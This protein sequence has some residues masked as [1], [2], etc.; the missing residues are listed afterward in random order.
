MTRL[1]RAGMIAAGVITAAIGLSLAGQ[2]VALAGAF[3]VTD[4]SSSISD[5]GSL[6]YAVANAAA[7]DTITIAPSPS[8]DLIT[9]TGTLDIAENLTITGPGA[10]AMAV[11]GGGTVGVF[12]ITSPGA[13]VGISGLTIENGGATSLGGDGIGIANDGGTVTITGSTVSGNGISAGGLSEGGGINNSGG[14]SVTI[15][16]ST[17]SGNTAPNGGGINNSGGGSVTITGSTVSG[18]SVGENGYGAG[19]ANNGGSLTITDSTVSGNSTGIGVNGGGGIYNDGSMTVTDSTVSGNYANVGGGGIYN[20]GTTATLTDSTVSGNTT[21]NGAGGG[22]FNLGGSMTLTDST[23]SG[24]S[25]TG[26]GNDGGGGGIGNS[27]GTVNVGATIVAG[28]TSGSG[29]DPNC[30]GGITSAGY[31][32]TDDATGG[33]C[34]FTQPTDLVNTNP[35]LGPL[36]DNGGPTQTMLPLAGSPAIGV[37]PPGTTLNGLTVCPRTDQRG[38]ASEAGGNCTI[39]AVEIPV[40]PAVTPITVTV[41]GSQVYGGGGLSFSQTS[42]APA[43]VTL[44]GSL[45]CTTAGGSPLGSLHAGSYTLDGSS[46]SG[47]SAAG[48]GSY[49]ISYAGAVNGFTVIPAPLTITASSA[50]MT[51]GTTPPAITPAYSGFVNGDGPGSLTTAPT[52]STTATSASPPGSYPSSCSG[53]ADPN[54]AISYDPGTVTVTPAACPSGTKANFRWHYTANGS[55]GGWSGT[56]TEPCPG[57]FSMGPQAMEGNLQVALGAT[58]QAGYDFTLPGN[59]NSLTMT[60]SAAK[61]TFAVACVSGATPSSA[62]LTVTLQAQ[63]YQI[64]NDQWYPS[65]DQSSPLVYQGS[66]TVPNL[67]GGGKISLAKG[68]T[69]TATLG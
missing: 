67:C 50:T 46:C 45:S 57:N 18:N 51:S 13:V 28:N 6:P 34:G 63:T 14:G 23:V 17:V 47:L 31:N 48:P 36:A 35:Q 37:I 12:D 11:S 7:G 19:I 44:T 33:P 56:T 55:A 32:L 68:G 24:N 3:T 20:D 58:L 29:N 26:S 27:S 21:R 69:F 16:G 66:A 65:G 9:L 22:I 15:T 52:C 8:C 41:S 1:R 62:T 25:A 30:S 59:H 5:T 53:A 64:T 38:V 61:V 40:P 10:A 42:N 39:G 60:V 54:Y 4:C 49:Q 43:G 2:G